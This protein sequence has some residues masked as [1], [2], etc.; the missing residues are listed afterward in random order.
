[1]TKGE[2][3]ELQKLARERAR[4]AK[5]GAR[6][7]TA[8]LKASFETEVVQIYDYNRDETWKEAV[9]AVKAALVDA[10]E[11]INER[12]DELGIPKELAPVVQGSWYGGPGDH[13]G[14]AGAEQRI[15]EIRRAAFKRIDALERMAIEEIDKAALRV[16]EQ[17]IMDGLTSDAAKAFMESMPT[18]EELMPQIDVQELLEQGNRPE[19]GPGGGWDPEDFGL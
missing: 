13:R 4:V 6:R 2:R 19:L 15:G 8:D 16:Q 7:R 1:M 10:Q 11:K 12:C 18:P 17:L 14:R 9:D 3:T 5:A